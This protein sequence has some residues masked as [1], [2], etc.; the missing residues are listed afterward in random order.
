MQ[1]T[2]YVDKSG[3]L[4]TNPFVFLPG[5]EALI[6]NLPKDIDDFL[7]ETNKVKSIPS[8]DDLKSSIKEKINNF[9]HQNNLKISTVKTII[10]HANKKVKCFLKCSFCDTK[11]SIRF[12]SS[13][14][15]SNT[16]R[17]SSYQ[18]VVVQI[19][20][21]LEFK[22]LYPSSTF[23]NHALP[24]YHHKYEFVKKIIELYMDMKYRK[25]VQEYG[26]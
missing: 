12:E 24:N 21:K 14:K 7:C 8:I 25:L 16:E 1:N 22:M 15:L 23:E 20:R 11:L 26:E 10:T 3:N 19:L 17:S 4:K 18:A 6:L 13:W 9:A 5:H 2:E